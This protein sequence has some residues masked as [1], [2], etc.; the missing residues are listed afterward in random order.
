[1]LV[2]CIIPT[3]K[4]FEYLENALNS[5]LIQNYPHIE[6]IIA[7]DGSDNFDKEH[8][9]LYIEQ[10]RQQNIEHYKL[11]SRAINVGTVKN[12]NY[13]VDIASGEIIIILASDDAFYSNNVVSQV[14]QRFNDSDCDILSCT[15]KL[16]SI[17]FCTELRNMPHQGYIKYI[18]TKMSSALEQYKHL[19]LGRLMEFAS[20]AALY[21]RK[22]FFEKLGG[23]DEQFVLWED[24]PFIAKITRLGYR[25]ET[26]YD[27]VAIKYR[28]GGISSKHSKSSEL[29]RIELDYCNLI[30]NEFL[31]H[32]ELFNQKENNIIKGMLIIQ[33]N[34][35][36]SG[37]ICFKYPM[38]VCNYYMDKTRKLI[39][40]YLLK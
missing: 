8:I 17:D 40:R 13:A 1:M 28:D 7:D 31:K 35:G 12:L 19:A 3:Y 29:S 20:G 14:V 25:I 21:Y 5:V 27:I 33:Q 2:S 26:A 36:I 6:L 18:N 15:R 24:G 38:S 11:L 16:C 30:E 32:A 9:G 37:K 4:K 39:F 10:N 34:R 22:S 23:Y